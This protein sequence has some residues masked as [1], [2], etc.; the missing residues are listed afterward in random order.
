MIDTLVICFVSVYSEVFQ[1]V[2]TH[3]ILQITKIIY[4]IKIKEKVKV[5]R[6]VRM[7]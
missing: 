3:Y 2:A 6:A 5:G 1:N 4:S 7:K